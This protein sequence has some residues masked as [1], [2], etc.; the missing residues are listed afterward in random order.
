MALWAGGAY[1][2][3]RNAGPGNALGAAL[4]GTWGGNI[5]YFGAILIRDVLQSK[6]RYRRTGRHYGL[7]GLGKN[8]WALFIEFGVAEALDTLVVRPALMYY[9][10]KALGDFTWGVIAAKFLADLSFYLPAILFYEWSKKR[11]REF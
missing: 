6:A 10:P 11:Y 8:L 7:P 2:A 4:A 1:L 3:A 5:G 9:L